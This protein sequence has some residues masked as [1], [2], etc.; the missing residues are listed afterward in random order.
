MKTLHKH[1]ARFL[2]AIRLLAV[3]ITC[4]VGCGTPAPAPVYERVQPPSAKINHHIVSRGESL[5]AIAWRYELD[6]RRL[7]E[8]NGLRQPY[9]IYPGQK[10]T[11][12]MTKAPPVSAR[13]SSKR[14]FAL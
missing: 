10:L 13:S 3:F 9:P 14:S 2:S 7:A 11:L 12:D 1:V 4:I 6:F 5:Y 8:V